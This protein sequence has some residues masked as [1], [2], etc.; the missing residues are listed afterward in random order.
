MAQPGVCAD[1]VGLVVAQRKDAEIAEEAV[2][3]GSS[4]RASEVDESMA[5]IHEP[6]GALSVGELERRIAGEGGTEETH[7]ERWSPVRLADELASVV[8]GGVEECDLARLEVVQEAGLVVDGG[9]GAERA[10][11]EAGEEAFQQ[12]QTQRGCQPSIGTADQ[13]RPVLPRA[14]RRRLKTTGSTGEDETW[15]IKSIGIE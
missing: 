6:W 15:G 11:E 5:P 4:L 7:G 13:R 3:I 10:G 1:L 12:T 14:Q 8:V 9:S 2:E